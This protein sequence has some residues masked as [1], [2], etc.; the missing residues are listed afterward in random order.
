[1]GT[2]TKRALAA[3]MASSESKVSTSSASKVAEGA[4]KVVDSASAV[5]KDSDADGLC[6]FGS[7]YVCNNDFFRARIMRYPPFVH[8]DS[9]FFEGK[10]ERCHCS[11]ACGKEEAYKYTDS[12]LLAQLK[13]A[14]SARQTEAPSA[15]AMHAS[16]E[17]LKAEAE[18]AEVV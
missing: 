6:E 17:D 13:D 18:A 3:A 7:K 11:C 10:D 5:A 16:T 1:M 2:I 8:E 14:T 9:P 4:S 12:Y 15:Q